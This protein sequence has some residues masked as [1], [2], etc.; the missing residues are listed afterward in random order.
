MADVFAA[1]AGVAGPMSLRTIAPC[2]PV[3]VIHFHGEFDEFT[4]FEGG[5]G[6]RSVTNTQHLSIP[7]TIQAWVA[8]NGCPAEPAIETLRPIVE[9]G[10]VIE[11]HEYAPGRAGSEVVLYYVARRRTY[12]ARTSAA[13][14]TVHLGQID[15]NL[16]ANDE[17]WRFFCK[18]PR[19][20]TSI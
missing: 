13:K 9:D 12:L 1:V 3:P 6:K 20:R 14:I 15:E 16:D 11:R 4:P 10:T 7:Y 18:H 17:I 8:A 5:K 19:N 2:R